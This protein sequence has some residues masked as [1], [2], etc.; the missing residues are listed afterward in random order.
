MR[1]LY[2]WECLFSAPVPL[3]GTFFGLN[4]LDPGILNILELNLKSGLKVYELDMLTIFLPFYISPIDYAFTSKFSCYLEYELFPK[5]AKFWLNPYCFFKYL[6]N[7][8]T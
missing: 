7:S 2:K 3:L 5:L 8:L 4:K 6:I 1:V